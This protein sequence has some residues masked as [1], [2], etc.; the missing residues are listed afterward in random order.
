MSIILVG[1]MDRLG[2]TYLEEAKKQGMSLRIFSQA[3][4]NMSCKI[5]HA[6]AVVIFTN[7]VSHQARDKAFT[8]AKKQSIPVFMHHAC[9]VCTLREYLNCL[10][11]IHQSSLQTL[12]S[13]G[14]DA[15][16]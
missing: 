15:D 11:L 9:S 8:A 12:R 16:N 2:E 3:E 6:D 7:K 4:Q 5:K 13:S 1:G 10:R 14:K